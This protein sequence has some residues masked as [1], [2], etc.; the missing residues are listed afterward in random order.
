MRGSTN[1]VHNISDVFGM[2]NLFEKAASEIRDKR[3]CRRVLPISGGHFAGDIL[4]F[5]I[6]VS[7]GYMMQ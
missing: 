2:S 7:V 6:R 1:Y 4:N 3:D 5:A